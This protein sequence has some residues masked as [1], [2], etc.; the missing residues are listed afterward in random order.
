MPKLSAEVASVAQVPRSLRVAFESHPSRWRE[1]RYVYPVISRRSRGLSIGVNL[2]PDMVCNFDCIYCQVD[3]SRPPRIS[4][5]DL[6]TLETELRGLLADPAVIFRDDAFQGVPAA[7]RALRNIAFSG[8]GE[9]TR[10]ECFPQAVE[11]VVRLRRELAPPQTRI[12]VITNACFLAEPSVA[13]ALAKLDGENGEIWAKLDAGTDEYY[14]RVNRSGYSLEHVLDGILHAGRQRPIVI[15]SLFM[16]IHGAAPPAEEIEA[17][18]GRLAEL[19]RGGCRIKAVQVYTVARRTA[20]PFVSELHPDELLAIAQRVE[21]A[22]LP[23]E[24]FT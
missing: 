3:R 23:V 17:Y 21:R 16:A 19:V 13:A 7:L 14:R 20:E 15:Q 2:N 18:V 4:D 1:N 8:D 12:V 5:V 9:P 10:A 11:R 22:G 24:C 6:D